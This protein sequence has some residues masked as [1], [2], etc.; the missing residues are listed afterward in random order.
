MKIAI[1]SDS[2]DNRENLGL[3]AQK[4]S[5]EKVECILHCGDVVAPSTLKEITKYNIPLHVIHGNN[6]G[7]LM[8]LAKMASDKTSKV[9]Y[10]GKDADI[11]LENKRIFIVHYPHYAEAM[12]LTGKYD[13]V[14][15]GHT[16]IASIKSLVNIKGKTTSVINA[17]NIAGIGEQ[18][19]Y[20]I[21]NLANMSF[22]IKDLV[23]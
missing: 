12:A 2:H 13:L 6:T 14:C 4:I 18:P 9:K 7:D 5:E 20:I 1:I 10:Y 21:G 3:V 22:E 11:Q 15:C 19:K 8:V 17:G 23:A 16:H